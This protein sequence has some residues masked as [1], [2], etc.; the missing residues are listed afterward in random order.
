MHEIA[1]GIVDPAEIKHREFWSRGLA[2]V[3]YVVALGIAEGIHLSGKVCWGCGNLPGSLN[4]CTGCG[5]ANYCNA[6]CQR[7][8]WK[9][10]H[11]QHCKFARTMSA[12][13]DESFET[14]TTFAEAAAHAGVSFHEHMGCGV[15]LSASFWLT[16]EL[17]QRLEEIMCRGPSMETFYKNLDRVSASHVW[18]FDDVQ[19]IRGEGEMLD[20][21]FVIKN[22]DII[23]AFLCFDVFASNETLEH[24]KS[25]VAQ[26]P[27]EKREMVSAEVFLAGYRSDA[28]ATNRKRFPRKKFQ[29][30]CKHRAQFYILGNCHP[31]ES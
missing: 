3:L 5:I 6:E 19:E 11:K 14:V 27:V 12:F 2:D 30:G 29:R 28:T 4:L 15:V 22:P 26:L 7:L 16:K 21:P 8:D 24:V 23:P 10:G 31:E 18:I 13:L 17:S 1:R 20:T 9:Q 25:L